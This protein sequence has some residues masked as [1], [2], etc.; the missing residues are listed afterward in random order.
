MKT[1]L[2]DIGKISPEVFEE[3]IYPHLGAKNPKILIGPQNG[4]DAGII[5]I[6]EKAVALTT[7]PFFVVP[8]YGWERS[9]WF[10]VHILL[11]D[12]VTSGLPPKYFSVDLNLP[13][14]ITEEQLETLWLVVDRE[15]KKYGVSVIAG[16]T[17]RYENCYYPMVGGATVIAVGDIDKY[18]GPSF[19][20]KGDKVIITKGPGIEASGIFATMFPSIIEEK[21]GKEFLQSAQG[22]FYQMSVVDDALTAVSIGVRDNGVSMMHDATECGVW[23][24]LYELAQASDK[25][26]I[27]EQDKIP[28]DDRVEKICK[29]FDID[30]YKSISEGTLLMFARESKAQKIVDTLKEKGIVAAIIGEVRDQNQGIKVLKEGKII[31]LEH[32][33]VDPFWKAFYK[34]LERLKK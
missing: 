14:E 8:E 22:L 6:G 10:A 24:G 5:E 20:K 7:D 26:I 30:P 21:E 12:I 33:G 9:A 23:G 15:L 16:H 27:I 1:K 31:P 28:M 19:V 2:P 32:P 4:V 11:S 3:L 29:I 25:G 18:V 17:A 13:M 34:T